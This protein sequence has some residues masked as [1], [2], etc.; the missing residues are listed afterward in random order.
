[1]AQ[2]NPTPLSQSFNYLPKQSYNVNRLLKLMIEMDCRNG[3]SKQIVPLDDFAEDRSIL[4]SRRLTNA[5]TNGWGHFR[6]VID[7]NC[8]IQNIN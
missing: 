5:I 7:E 6:T 1:M 4:V 2:I 8:V 3:L